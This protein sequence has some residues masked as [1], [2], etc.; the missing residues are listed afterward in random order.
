MLPAIVN[1]ADDIPSGMQD[2]YTQQDDGTFLLEVQPIQGHALEDV[3]GLKRS[4]DSEQTRFNR[5]HSFLTKVLGFEWNAEK[6]RYEGDDFDL[7]DLRQAQ[8]RLEEL[9]KIDPAKE[10]DKL[11]EEK[12]RQMAQSM[13]RKLKREQEA[14]RE[15]RDALLTQLEQEM[16]TREA[17]QAIAGANGSV[18]LLLPLVE[19][20]AYLERGEDGSMRVLLK[21]PKGGHRLT[22]EKGETGPMTL[23]E[24]IQ[25]LSADP[26]FKRAFDGINR[27]GGGTGKSEGDPPRD[28]AKK[29]I[30]ATDGVELGR[31]LKEMAEGNVEVVVDD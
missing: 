21:D 16:I 9:E 5:A 14:I 24:R 7:D 22:M 30:S 17:T 25:E 29:R 1:S 2:H 11:A 8:K 13:E 23:T 6:S 12:A 15:E 4:L 27:S 26:T 20:E 31:N 19:R 10:A 3:T 18:D 28:G